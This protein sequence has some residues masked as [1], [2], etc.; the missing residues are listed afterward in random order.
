LQSVPLVKSII[1]IGNE[2]IIFPQ[3]LGTEVN[4][5]YPLVEE[6]GKA[7]RKTDEVSEIRPQEIHQE[8]CEVC[9]G[10]EKQAEVPSDWLKQRDSEGLVMTESIPK[11]SKY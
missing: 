7:D 2:E 5:E 10:S 9:V 4:S 8:S 6:K 1:N 3:K 11:S